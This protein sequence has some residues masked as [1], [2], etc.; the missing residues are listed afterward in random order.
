VRATARR[1]TVAD[2][3]GPP[4]RRP[5]APRRCDDEERR[6]GWLRGQPVQ[7]RAGRCLATEQGHRYRHGRRH[8]RTCPGRRRRRRCRPGRCAGPTRHVGRPWPHRFGT[9]HRWGPGT[10]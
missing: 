7:V 2:Q 3:T 9:P 10:P 5:P 6:G 1:S 4:A 8:R